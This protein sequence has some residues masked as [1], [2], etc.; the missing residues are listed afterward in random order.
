MFDIS[1]IKIGNIIANIKDAVARNNIGTLSEL[2]TTAKENLVDAINEVYDSATVSYAPYDTM[3]DA[4][5]DDTIT[6]GKF[7]KTLGYYNV[8]DG[9]AGEYYVSESIDTTKFNI[10][11]NN[12][13]YA[14]LIDDYSDVNVLKC[15][16]KGGTVTPSEA[17]MNS[18]IIN[19]IITAIYNAHPVAALST[20]LY[21]G[22][23]SVY[24]P[25]G[26]YQFNASW[27]AVNAKINLRIHGDC[28]G[29][30]RLNI[31]D[32][33]N[34]FTLISNVGDFNQYMGCEI[35][36]LIFT[37]FTCGIYLENAV[38]CKIHD[39]M[40]EGCTTGIR[41]NTFVGCY[42]YGNIM[43]GG[44]YGIFLEMGNSNST[45]MYIHHNWIAHTSISGIW[46]REQ[47]THGFRTTYLEDNIFEYCPY[48]IYA[49]IT[50][51]T[52]S[53]LYISRC[54]IEQ[55]TTYAI[56]CVRVAIRLYCNDIDTHIYMSNPVAQLNDLDNFTQGLTI[57]GGYNNPN[58]L[59][60]WYKNDHNIIDTVNSIFQVPSNQ[61]VLSN[62]PHNNGVNRYELE[63]S[64]SNGIY[65]CI[66]KWT[67]SS[68]AFTPI[69]STV[70]ADG[71]SAP[72][73]NVSGTIAFSDAGN[74]KK[75]RIKYYGEAS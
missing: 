67:P 15:G 39:N 46:I 19:N 49:S 38:N 21:R 32:I 1:K 34:N 36:H 53:R 54:H 75:L 42:I 26:T 35:D 2:Y 16:L 8:N 70:T 6:A 40:F 28:E 3:I 17:T 56:Y 65:K 43:T 59:L 60:K 30:T 55:C 22:G 64:S 37:N 51:A 52:Y 50:Q 63:Y 9:G 33:S 66:G 20:G 41:V 18:T 44:A 58:L 11:L 25:A 24:I 45:T 14:H 71:I 72:T 31:K 69:A 68:S 57:N 4:I 13:K 74:N 7:I 48:G 29:N 47:G 62:Y 5:A 27:S 73:T 12:G 10:T 61:I 23:G